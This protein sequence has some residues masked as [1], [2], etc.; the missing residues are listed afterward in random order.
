M[1]VTASKL[2]ENIYGLLDQVI[3]TGTPLEVLRKGKLLKIVP[4]KPVSK[5]S[6]L[7]KHKGFKGDPDD[8]IHMDWLA[9]WSE[10]K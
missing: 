1:R 6:R 9:D 3:T 5:L 8:I 4:E 2:R 7:R 10:L